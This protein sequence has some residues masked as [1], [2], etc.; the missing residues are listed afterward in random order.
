MPKCKIYIISQWK[1]EGGL[2]GRFLWQ[3]DNESKY[4]DGD[5]DKLYS[6]TCL[7]Q[8]YKDEMGAKLTFIMG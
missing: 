2:D 5:S 8:N 1:W 6:G 7:V 4:T 3:I